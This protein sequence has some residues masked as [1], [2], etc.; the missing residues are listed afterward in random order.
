M[1]FLHN[2]FGCAQHGI[3]KRVTAIRSLIR[4]VTGLAPYEKRVVELIKS[5]APKR[6]LK[7]AKKRLGGHV[8]GKAKKDELT[9]VIMKGALSWAFVYR[10]LLPM[11]S[12]LCVCWPLP[13]LVRRHAHFVVVCFV[14]AQHAKRR[15]NV[16]MLF[17][18]NEKISNLSAVAAVAALDGIALCSRRLLPV[19]VLCVRSRA[20]SAPMRTQRV[21]PSFSFQLWARAGQ[22][23]CC[24]Y[25]VLVR[26]VCTTV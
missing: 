14:L 15:S 18:R 26:I 6:A 10:L 23:T 12:C 2:A 1:H 21:E 16:P 5:N 17:Y 19:L 9:E 8:R 24:A 25:C 3:G 22:E 13:R 20:V 7:Y 11:C 4:E